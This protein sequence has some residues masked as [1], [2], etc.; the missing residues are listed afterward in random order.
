MK[1]SAFTYPASLTAVIVTLAFAI[2]AE[3]ATVIGNSTSDRGTTDGFSGQIFMLNAG[4]NSLV[5]QTVSS[6]SFFNNQNTNAVT[7]VLIED[8]GGGIWAVRGIGATIVSNASGIQGGAF[9]LVSGSAI[10]GLN[11]YVGYYDGSWDGFSATPNTGGVEWDTVDDP[12]V[13]G[14]IDSLGALWTHDIPNGANNPANMGVGA[15]NSRDTVYGAAV[16]GRHASINFT[17]VPEPSIT[18]LAG[19]AALA[20]LRRRR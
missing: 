1:S 7:P 18:A 11:Y 10:I 17:A 8:M 3:G 14:Q 12:P 2:P 6:W 4:L 20:L 15:I 16:D 5:G 13:G 9:N 19:I